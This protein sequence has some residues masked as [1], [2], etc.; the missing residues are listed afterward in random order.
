MGELRYAFRVE[1]RMRIRTLIGLAMLAVAATGCADKGETQVIP[2]VILGMLETTPPSYDD[3]QTQL[4]EVY[5]PVELPLRRPTDAERPTGPADPYSRP[6]FQL[7]SDTR[8]TARFTLSNLEN[9]PHTV[10]LLINPWNEFVRYEPG[11]VIGAA[12]TTPNLSGIDHFFILPP[13]GRVEGIIT[14]DDFVELAT[15]LA[16]A[17]KLKKQPVGPDS[18]FAGPALYNRA[19]NVQNRSSVFDPLLAPYIPK[20][21]AGIVGFNLGLRTGEPSKVAIEVILDVQDVNGDRVIAESDKASRVGR[22]GTALVPPAPPA[23]P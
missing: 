7:A 15:D 23:P 14:P 11:I 5:L 20:V 19:F 22:P 21:I 1:A 16:T 9:V 3:G 4:F 17:M 8:V 13:L 18:Q 6:P 10:E 2:P 12:A